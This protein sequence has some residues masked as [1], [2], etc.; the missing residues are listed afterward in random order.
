[1]FHGR[2]IDGGVQNYQ[3][4]VSPKETHQ[5]WMF[6]TEFRRNPIFSVDP[7]LSTCHIPTPRCYPQLPFVQA[8]VKL[9]SV[10]NLDVYTKKV[11]PEFPGLPSGKLT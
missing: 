3:C 10:F 9:L 11:D 4:R 1:M 8:M 7:R 6:T 5:I 2:V